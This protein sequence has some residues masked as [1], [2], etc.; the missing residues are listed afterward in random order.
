MQRILQENHFILGRNFTTFSLMGKTTEP[1]HTSITH[2]VRTQLHYLHTYPLQHLLYIHKCIMHQFFV[3]Q[4]KLWTHIRS[5]SYT[6]H[7]RLLLSLSQCPITC[8]ATNILNKKWAFTLIILRNILIMSMCY[9]V[10]ILRCTVVHSTADN[11]INVV[12]Q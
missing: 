11:R 12:Y 3:I 10:A 9:T 8:Y 1:W 5:Q 7:V 4:N 2:F 6:N